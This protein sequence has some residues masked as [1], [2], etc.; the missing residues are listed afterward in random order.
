MAVQLFASSIF[1]LSSVP[2][3]FV[4][5]APIAT[6]IRRRPAGGGCA[7]PEQPPAVGLLPR[8]E[9]VV[10]PLRWNGINRRSKMTARGG[11]N[12]GQAQGGGRGKKRGAIDG[13][14]HKLGH[15]RIKREK[16]CGTSLP[17]HTRQKRP[18]PFQRLWLAVP[19]GFGKNC[20]TSR[21]PEGTIWPKLTPC[22]I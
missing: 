10:R 9:G 20:P 7:V 3:S 2:I 6:R 13:E 5:A 17:F 19:A 8:G 4:P 14:F 21:K 11:E 16:S 1:V 12:G 18:I 22:L 15:Y